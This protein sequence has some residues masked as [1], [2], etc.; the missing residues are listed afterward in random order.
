MPFLPLG[1]FSFGISTD[2]IIGQQEVLQIGGMI[3]LSG[4]LELLVEAIP[5]LPD[6]IDAGSAL[7]QSE[8]SRIKHLSQMFLETLHH[9][10]FSA[11]SV[12]QSSS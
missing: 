3:A 6:H 8:A 5:P 9:L 4:P 1:E 10:S 7:R 12:S 2:L 11:A